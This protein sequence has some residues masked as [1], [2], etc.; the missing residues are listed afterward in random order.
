MTTASMTI[1]PGFYVT[2]HG[3]PGSTIALYYSLGKLI[4]VQFRDILYVTVNYWMGL[5]AT[6]VSYLKKST[7]VY[8]EEVALDVLQEL[9]EEALREVT[10]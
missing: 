8:V 9:Y 5:S 4:G 1:E 3:K 7:A 10:R 2:F 6:H